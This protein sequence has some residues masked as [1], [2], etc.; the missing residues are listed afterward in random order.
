[1][2]RFLWHMSYI[3]IMFFKKTHAPCYPQFDNH[4]GVKRRMSILKFPPSGS[5]TYLPCL[6]KALILKVRSVGPA[7]LAD[8]WELAGNSEPKVPP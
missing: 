3:S 7:A 8:P 4:C 5:D 1:M 6:Y 2:G